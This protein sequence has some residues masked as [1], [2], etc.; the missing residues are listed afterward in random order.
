MSIG[1]A[2]Y[3]NIYPTYPPPPTGEDRTNPTFAPGDRTNFHPVTI[4]PGS[5]LA[6]VLK[7]EMLEANSR[8]HQGFDKIG[9]GLVAT[10]HAADGLVE[11]FEDPTLP[12]W[13]AVQWH[14]ENL[15][16]TPHDRLFAA[17]VEAAEAYRELT[18][19]Q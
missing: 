17:L 13:L 10:A 5:R 1:A 18:A 8:H 3:T 11:A 9:H 15:G 6:D 19:A 12:F 7:T 14:P 4:R 2:R 16:G